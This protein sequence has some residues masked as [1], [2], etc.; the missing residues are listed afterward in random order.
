MNKTLPLAA[1]VLLIGVTA[2]VAVF[3]NNSAHTP[4]VH[5]QAANG[6]AGEAADETPEVVRPEQ[7]AD[8]KMLELKEP[9]ARIK[10]LDWI[11]GQA[12]AR[13]DSPVLRKTIVGDPDESVQIHAVETALRLAEK[14]G[15]GATARVVHMAL[16]STRGNTRAR[17]LKAATDTPQQDLVPTLIELVDNNDDYATMALNALAYTDSGE[18]HAKILAIAEDENAVP[19]LRERAVALLGVTKDPEGYNVLVELSN[20]D[21]QTLRRIAVEVLKVLN[22]K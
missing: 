14:E 8:A 6:L 1:L 2:L 19:R 13:S 3:W 20:G 10:H 4:D 12:W 7:E 18:A 22:E 17:G 5:P 16:V 11:A 15:S 9:A 21:N